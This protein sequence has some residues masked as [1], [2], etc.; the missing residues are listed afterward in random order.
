MAGNNRQSKNIY[1]ENDYENIILVDPNKVV[2][3]NG[4]VE[5]RLVEHENLIFY[6][7]LEA[8]VL[9]RTKLAV[10]SDLDDS[11]INTS[12][13][14][15][16]EPGL[17][18]IN[19]LNPRGKLALDTSWSDQQTGKGST[20]GK[21][22][23]QIQ[24]YLVGQQPNQKLVR[25]SINVQDTQGLGIINIKI[26]N[27][28]A[29][30]P[31]V[32]IEMV[33]VQGRTLFEQ[34]DL[35][36]YSAFFQLP[37]PIFYLTVKGYYG[38]AVRYELMLKKFNAR[39]DPSD[40]NYK[41]TTEFI[42][43]TSAILEDIVVQHLFTG[44]R[45]YTK[46]ITKSEDSTAT[47]AQQQEAQSANVSSTTAV[48]VQNTTK[49]R[50][51]LSEVYSQYKAKGLL[52][53]NFEE[54]TLS[55][56]LYRLESL[57]RYINE[58]FGPQELEVLNDIKEYRE[59][60]G[61]FR[62]EI[63]SSTTGAFYNDYIDGS[64]PI[65]ESKTKGSG[66]IYYPLKKDIRESSEKTQKANTKLEEII[67]KYQ[68]I[69]NKNKT[70]G[71]NGSYTLEN[72]DTGRLE[73]V[74]SQIN[75]IVN[76]DKIKKTID[77]NKIDYEKTFI[78]RKN[79][80]PSEE[81]LITFT[82]NLKTELLLQ[83]QV[84]I[85]G[86]LVNENQPYYVFGDTFDDSNFP[87]NTFLW[88]LDVME[89]QFNREEQNIETS[90]SKTLAK[91]ITRPAA[92]GG[93]GFNPTIRNTLG[94][95][96]ANADAFLR[97]MDNTHKAAYDQRTNPIRLTSIIDP[98]KNFGTDT[99]D[100]VQ[101]VTVDGKLTEDNIV[102]PWPQYFETELDKD[103]NSSYVV[104]YPGDPKSMSK[105]KGYLYDV[106]PEIQ[107]V[108]EYLKGSVQKDI[109]ENP[110]GLSNPA[111]ETEF[112]GVSAIEF[113]NKIQPYQDKTET[114]FLYEMF[115]RAML[116]SDYTKLFRPSSN[117]DSVYELISD[118][119]FHNVFES[120][121]DSPSLNNV[122]KNTAFT[123]Q[124]FL[125]NI[126]QQSDRGQ[127]DDWIEFSKGNFVTPSI[128]DLTSSPVKIY[129]ITVFEDS[130]EVTN[131]S[132]STESIKSYL[133]KTTSNEFTTFDTYPFVSLE[134]ERTNLA[135]GKT[136]NSVFD[137]NNTT[138]TLVFNEEKKTIAS[139]ERNDN[140]YDKT[141]FT[142]TYWRGNTGE[143]STQNIL[144]FNNFA[145]GGS[146]T[147][148]LSQ[149]TRE[150]AKKFYNDKNYE[151]LWITE[152]FVNYG[153]EYGTSGITEVQ[154]T[155]LLNTPY[156]ANAISEAVT[157]YS[158]NVPAKSLGYLLINSLPLA[159]LREKFKSF[160]DDDVETELDYVWSVMNKFSAVHKVPYAWIIK[161][162]SI[163]HRYKTYIE[164]G[165]DILDNVWKDYDYAD[166]YDP[167]N[168][169]STKTYDYINYTGGTSSV[170]QQI[171]QTYVNPLIIQ[172]ST[173]NVGIYP[174]IINDTY[175][176][177]TGQ[178]LFPNLSNIDLTTASSKN[179]YI[180]KLNSSQINFGF[181]FDSNNPLRSFYL[182]NYF[183]YMDLQSN[184]DIQNTTIEDKKILMYPS[185]GF[186]PFNQSKFECTNSLNNMTQEFTGNTS[187]YN[188]SVRSLWLSPNY[189]YYNNNL[190]RKPEY[191]EYLK[192]IYTGDS[193][194]N[195]FSLE[196]DNQ[197]SNIEEIFSI[198]DKE[199]LDI[200]E[201]EFLN[202]CK[203]S[204]D[205]INLMDGESSNSTFFNLV[206]A[207]NRRYRNIQYL[208]SDIL[209]ISG[210]FT[211]TNNPEKDSFK[212]ASLQM[213]SVVS[214]IKDFLNYDIVLKLGNP[215]KYNRRIFGSFAGTITK[216]PIIFGN[217]IPGTL[218]G[219]S[220]LT[221]LSVSQQ[222][223][224]DEW[225]AL[226]TY[227]GFSTLSGFT[228]TN[229]GSFIT[230]F[231][232]ENN[233]EF[234][235][236]NIKS[237][238]QIIKIYA[239]QNVDSTTT[240]SS[241]QFKTTIQNLLNAQQ[242]FRENI[243]NGTLLQLRV[244]LPTYTISESNST[245]SV[246]DGEQPKLEVYTTLKNLNDKW[247]AGG[248][249]KTRTLF[250]DFLFLDRANRDIG[251]SFMI[252][253]ISLKSY[254]KGKVSSFS[255]MSLIG[256]ILSQNNFIFMALPSYINFYG[257]QDTSKNGTPTFNPD[258][259]NSAFGTFLSV[260]YQDSKPKFLCMYVGKPSE[261]LDMK[262]NKTSRFK[263]D[264][265]DLRRGSNNPLLENQSNKTDWSKSNKVVGFN[266]DFGIRNQ[267]IFKS[268]SLDQ[269]QYKN[270]SETFQVLSDMANQAA[271]DKVAQQTTSLYNIYRTRSY[272]CSVS[273][274]GNMM[275]QPTMYFNLRHVPMFYGPYFITNVNHDIT[276]NGFETTFE[277]VRQPIFAFPSIDKLVT[278]VNKSLLKK[279]E[280]VYRK[281]K[282]QPRSENS[283]NQENNSVTTN[284]LTPSES[285]NC[286]DTTFYPSLEF[287]DFINTRI[288][289]NDVINYLN[290][291]INYNEYLRIFAL[292]SA[293]YINS[294]IG[295]LDCVNNNLYGISSNT[296]LWANLTGFTSGQVCVNKN[297][298]SKPIFTFEDFKNSV[299]FFIEVYVNY[300]SIIENLIRLDVTSTT[301]DEKTAK[302]LTYLYLSTWANNYGIGNT[303]N[304][305]KTTTDENISNNTISQQTFDKI[306]EKMFSAS[307]KIL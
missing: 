148:G 76:K 35:S 233:I 14:S 10:G 2:L 132:S 258:I 162:G 112:I 137:S 182:N 90:I 159:T 249:F 22:I 305:I 242:S 21:G 259:A 164:T 126:E 18:E 107:F 25:R 180:G 181:G 225:K 123:Y 124:T 202:F 15:L 156:F 138:K 142:S 277:G 68:E 208:M 43:R 265:F 285:E 92:E 11:V 134:W 95:I 3:P 145:E 212:L 121:K 187:I 270:T 219:D 303:A 79:R 299:N 273:S 284:P 191:N 29:Y 174:K 96:C 207:T 73:T 235:V 105:T 257:I 217:Y 231:F 42:G 254:L 135:N 13:A 199:T 45:M 269:N 275:I 53:K 149:I 243:L 210:D 170:V 168:G 234:T 100:S 103:G 274:M 94:V 171:N 229:N 64:L 146:T 205:G 169:L 116:A 41:I 306:Y 114:N 197:Y 16:G 81:E 72:F 163:W 63:F 203:N 39:F 20:E 300:V 298:L 260:D 62:K 133:S 220:E 74:N 236:E 28:P 91:K 52:A 288:P 253:I 9:P 165:V 223:F 17:Q 286:N 36:P 264:I 206:N 71:T 216:E 188:G 57:E 263:N 129:D 19:F 50:Q 33:D 177:F 61:L 178:E 88:S 143:G 218:P 167:V 250:E 296:D 192:Q 183:Q 279:Y 27:N 104:K 34:G 193:K 120:V 261:H 302:A 238:S 245:L 102:Y 237:L 227:V 48:S 75:F 185:C 5:E 32:T 281:K 67:K 44:P 244:K 46:Q 213:N 82:A 214:S 307:I 289:V 293:T 131:G 262:E 24:E 292:G 209:C 78:I 108:E 139:F 119:E 70:F 224:P 54:L 294:G 127:S 247:I 301:N 86:N 136:I 154:T 194:Q 60:L 66:Y 295:S 232:I 65:V 230:D 77:E 196:S 179:L 267:N 198:F 215:S 97:L 221:P 12:V 85:N 246:I 155:S 278:S 128:I 283:T 184:P 256:Y 38:K 51:I 87:I 55:E 99:K 80:Q 69:L 150:G 122:L 175:N 113:P 49:G 304:N 59:Q 248:N 268:I 106:W 6:A 186:L 287:V 172:Q 115:E 118:F 110:R 190:I 101:K 280:E 211:K 160:N 117:L 157:N 176:F 130:P 89:R 152:S 153:N 84:L 111:I 228:Y 8:K 222:A 23:N 26:Q 272:T 290:S 109:P 189:G 58:Q 56:F 37:Y 282:G 4:E 201:T 7:N 271:G 40:G 30:I 166:G 144:N 297:N 240:V 98:D 204:N 241:S 1:V 173:M 251:D 239:T 151:N 226:Q 158:A 83:V 161:Y 255:L 125:R 195:S 141:L 31:Q 276:I 47:S 252:D 200:F 93:L 291:I 140:V 147:V 266:L